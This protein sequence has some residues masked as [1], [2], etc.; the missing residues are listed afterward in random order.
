MVYNTIKFNS[1]NR[2]RILFEHEE[3]F[4][5]MPSYEYEESP[6]IFMTIVKELLPE[7]LEYHLYNTSDYSNSID[8]DNMVSNFLLKDYNLPLNVD[9]KYKI[10]SREYWYYF[11]QSIHKSRNIFLKIDQEALN[12]PFTEPDPEATPPNNTKKKKNVI[13]QK[14]NIFKI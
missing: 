11:K 2:R 12:E 13:D 10:I 6:L 5:E 7:V 8:N 9:N 14:K 1:F 4:I 3:L